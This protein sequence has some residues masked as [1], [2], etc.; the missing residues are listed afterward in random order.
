MLFPLFVSE[1]LARAQLAKIL[2]R[3]PRASPG[4]LRG[5]DEGL[6]GKGQYTMLGGWAV[7]QARAWRVT[8]ELAGKSVT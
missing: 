3:L 6:G 8:C 2:I 5:E 4:L 1:A 7:L